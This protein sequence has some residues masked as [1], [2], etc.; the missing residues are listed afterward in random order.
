MYT[1]CVYTECEPACLCI[2]V[3]VLYKDSEREREKQ[4]STWEQ[5]PY[6]LIQIPAG[7]STATE[8]GWASA[9]GSCVGGPGC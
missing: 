2:H 5:S 7:V 8:A 3:H 1:V 9:L 4:S 6:T